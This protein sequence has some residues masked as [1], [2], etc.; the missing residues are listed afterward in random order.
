MLI[1]NVIIKI[2]SLQLIPKFKKERK[3]GI[4]WLIDNIARQREV[5]CMNLTGLCPMTGDTP[6]YVFTQ[7]GE[8]VILMIDWRSESEEELADE[9]GF[10]GQPPQYFSHK[11]KRVSPVWLLTEFAR[12]YK[13][14]MIDANVKVTY[15]W[16]VLISN[17]TFINYNDMTFI[18]EMAGVTVFHGYRNTQMPTVHYANKYHALAL[19][20]YKAFVFWCER[21]G[22]IPKDPYAFEEIDAD[23]DEMEFGLDKDDNSLDEHVFDSSLASPGTIQLS[24][25]KVV[26]VEILRPMPSPRKELEKMVGCQSVKT[27][28]SDLLELTRYNKWMHI[29]YPDWKQH[30][31]SL[32]ALFLGRPG[33]GK[34]TVCKIY[35]ALLKEVGALSKGHV[36]VCNRGTFVGSN[37]GDEESAIRQVLEMAKGGVLM[38]DEAYMLNSGNPNDP[39]K[40]IIPQFMDVLS[41]ERQ[42]DVAIVLCGYKEPMQKL[43]DLNPGLASRFPNRFE[44]NDFSVEEL[45]QITLH[46]LAEYGYHFTRAGLIKY[47]TVLTEAYSVRNPNNWGN[48]RYVTNLL[49]RIY[50]LHAKRCMKHNSSHHLKTFFSITPSDIQ[51]IDIPKEKK[52]IGF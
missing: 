51:P 46:R 41:N 3:L 27:Q 50:L 52:R 1:K 34:T 4:L 38:I 31:V 16:S 49:E 25:N 37:W 44:F 24:Q 40:L 7:K 15:V 9:E 22:C 33:T 14:I 18:W 11:D 2:M 28:I 47:R 43:L 13:Q 39:G 45:M 5:E 32:H 35:G 36:V 23:Y 10:I 8:V 26:N 42:R 29:H 19:L 20:Q 48:A 17:S 21:Q 12:Q 30:Q 6:V